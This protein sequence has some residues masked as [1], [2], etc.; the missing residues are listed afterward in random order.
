MQLKTRD[1]G[2]YMK[3]FFHDYFYSIV[4]MFVNQ[5]AIA[6]FGTSLTFATTRAHLESSGFDALTLIVSIFSVAF[7]LFLIYTLMWEVGAKDKISVDVG[8]KPYRPYLG[9]VMSLIANIPNIIIAV[10]YL[11]AS[12]AG[13]NNMTFVVRLVGSLLQG[14]YFGTLI[15]VTVPLGGAYIAVNTL[16]PTFFIIVAPALI[17]CWIA[18]YLGHKNI[19]LFGSSIQKET[20][21]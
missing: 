20:K 16:W 12:I 10:L 14:M 9:L 13:S 15:T 3:K 7:Y 11:I 21:K 5:V 2:G 1:S 4:K 6:L 8:K 19:K 18:Y 17:T